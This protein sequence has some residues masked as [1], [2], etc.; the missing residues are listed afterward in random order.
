M[1]MCPQTSA[2]Q[3]CV[4]HTCLLVFNCSLP[5]RQP[6]VLNLFIGTKKFAKLITPSLTI[7]C[8]ELESSLNSDNY[9]RLASVAEMKNNPTKLPIHC[10]FLRTCWLKECKSDTDPTA[11]HM[12]E[13]NAIYIC[14]TGP[15]EL[16]IN[17]GL[18]ET[19]SQAQAGSLSGGVFGKRDRGDTALKVGVNEST[20]PFRPK[21][22][23]FIHTYLT[24]L[25]FL[26][27]S[28]ATPLF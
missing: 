21:G 12:P 9:C 3:I 27:L 20:S 15:Q 13:E 14:T 24:P 10:I 1:A 19:R 25:W 18:F 28:M 6:L 16:Q 22:G 26:I 17:Q 5:P 11:T 4:G 8:L 7:L 2:F 23:Q